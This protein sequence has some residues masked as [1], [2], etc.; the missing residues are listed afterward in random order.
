MFNCMRLRNRILRR[1]SEVGVEDIIIYDVEN[2]PFGSKVNVDG[3]KAVKTKDT[4]MIEDGTEY[5]ETKK[6][7]LGW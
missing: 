5:N 4:I 7:T 3:I 2:L 1:E 6:V